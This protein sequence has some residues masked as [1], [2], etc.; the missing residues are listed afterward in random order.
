MR[1]NRCGPEALLEAVAG[2]FASAPLIE[3]LSPGKLSTVSGLRGVKDLRLLSYIATPASIAAPLH[4]A[5]KDGARKRP[6][7]FGELVLE[8]VNATVRNALIGTNTV[9]GYLLL[10]V[11]LSY[12]LGRELRDIK[13]W[14]D[15]EEVVSGCAEL[16]KPYLEVEDCGT[17][18]AA[19]AKACSR[20]SLRSFKG[21]VPDVTSC[22]GRVCG[23]SVWE[24]LINSSYCDLNSAEVVGGFKLT[25]YSLSEL[26]RRLQRA[27][28]SPRLSDLLK[29]ISLTHATLLT[30]VIDTLVV[31]DLGLPT[32]MLVRALARS[33]RPGTPAWARASSFLRTYDVNPASIS[34]V[35]ATA[36]ALYL[37]GVSIE[38][39]SSS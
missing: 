22:A 6:L 31:R 7:R 14:D 23:Y 32:A 11:P 29:A 21:A 13:C 34:D 26:R 4:R 27:S 17:L 9:L 33:L 37:V 5:V 12:V 10:A 24:V 16:I 20:K 18:Y 8:G 3:A 38:G 25:R 39:W 1:G 36:V 15:V 28:N 30:K 35:L 19:I 2:A